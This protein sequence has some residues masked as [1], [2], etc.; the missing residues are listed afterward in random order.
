MP[1][2]IIITAAGLN[3]NSNGYASETAH[4]DVTIENNSPS[5]IE[6]ITLSM[7]TTSASLTLTDATENVASIASGETLDLTGIFTGDIAAVEDGHVVNCT[8]TADY[9]L[10]NVPTQQTYHFSFIVHSV[11]HS[12]TDESYTVSITSGNS[13]A[14]INPGENIKVT[15]YSRNTGNVNAENIVSTLMTTSAYAT[16]EENIVNFASAVPNARLTSQYD[17]AID[18]N[19]TD[20]TTIVFHHTITDGTTSDSLSFDILVISDEVGVSENG[21]STITLYPNPTSTDVTVSLGDGIKATHIRLSN[22]FGQLIST[23]DIN[24]SSA[25]VNMSQL[26]NGIYFV[27]IYNSNELITTSKVV[28]K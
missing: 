2:G 25:V 3:A 19:T 22:T 28:K 4:F 23:T 24:H 13:D 16:I 6:D 1:E 15:V 11:T 27:Q 8:V 14:D 12:L 26:P 10:E 5:A 7:T 20:N 21:L 17:I 18:P 9:L